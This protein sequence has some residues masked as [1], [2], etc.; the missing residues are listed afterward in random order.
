MI[1]VVEIPYNS[2]LGYVLMKI[3]KLVAC[4]PWL[5][6]FISSSVL[7]LHG[8][9]PFSGTIFIDSD[10]ITPND[11]TNYLSISYDGTDERT[12]YDRR[13]GWVD[14]VP[15]LFEANFSDLPSVEIQVNPEF[16]SV[17]EARQQAERFAPVIGRLP[18]CLRKDVETVW[19][20]KGNE[21]FGGGNN[22]LLIH[23]EQADDY[24]KDGILEETLVHEAVHT[25]L[26]SSHADADAWKTAQQKDNGYIS[27]YAQE[28]PT[29]EDVAESF[30]PYFAIRFRPDRI[31]SE[32]K[33]TIENTIPNRIQY[34]DDQKLEY[35]ENTLIGMEGKIS[36]ID[37]EGGFYGI[38]SD[39]GEEFLAINLQEELK[40]EVG[41]NILVKSATKSDEPNIYMWGTPIN[42]I[43]YEISSLKA[44]NDASDHGN[45][46]RSLD[47]FGYYLELQ[48]N[49]IYHQ[50]MGWLYRYGEMTDSSW[51]YSNEFNSWLWT[52]ENIF[53]FLFRESNQRWLYFSSTSKSSQFFEFVENKW[54]LL[55]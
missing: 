54:N 30:L 21:P 17:D 52:S 49:W 4:I 23:I 33:E 38:I 16:G 39:S 26:D 2:H 31:S 10:I 1:M 6:V 12:M 48:D 34:F 53:P 15:Y 46:W 55:D 22:N 11:E 3:G 35:F 18:K 42:V 5:Y 50:Y 47:W 41:Q 45:G 32:L 14:L 37:L 28:Y 24:E 13:S 51:F 29:R 7:Q 36:F 8:D 19:I 25:S 9:P 27:T 43:S 44:W 40:K 20:H